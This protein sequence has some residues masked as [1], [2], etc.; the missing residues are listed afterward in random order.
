M[1][2]PHQPATSDRRAS[3]ASPC[4][5][6]SRADFRPATVTAIVGPNGAGKSTLLACL[7]GLRRPDGGQVRLGSRPS[8]D[9]GAAAPAPAA[10]ASCPRRRRSLGRWRRETLVGLGRT[11]SSAPAAWRRR[12][13]GRHRPRH[14]RTRMASSLADRDVTTL[15]GGER[16][17]ALIARALAGEPE[18]LLADEP[19]GRPRP[20]P[21]ARRRRPVPRLAHE[22]G[23][24]RGRHPARPGHAALHL[25]DRVH[26]RPRA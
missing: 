12:G 20:R 23:K 5:T 7:A 26:G 13:R 10:S 21:P 17:R 25:A 3:A 2:Q 6:A 11:P 14:G 18:W 22:E 4:W 1:S 24:R 8:P 19:S 9:H 15:S 16:A